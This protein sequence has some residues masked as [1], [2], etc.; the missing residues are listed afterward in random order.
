MD[1][2][3]L[4]LVDV[5]GALLDVAR[6]AEAVFGRL[7]AS[8]LNWKPDVAQWSIA[9]CFDHLLNA[10]RMMFSA[11]A[12]ALSGKQPRT[13][14]ERVP[15][16]PRVLGPML[17][18]SQA[19]AS[20]RKF[21]AP[22]QA[23]PAESDLPADIIARFVVHHRELADAVAALDERRA[24]ALVMTSPFIGV[25]TYSVLDGWRL[26]VAHDHRHFEQARRVRSLWLAAHSESVH[27]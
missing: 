19:P 12:E 23:R 24:A 2:T 18:R 27:S 9:Q 16:L 6:D 3:N 8:Q 14:W 17:I 25:V 21:V 22:A 26:I 4:T 5:R 7:N 15:I 10:N 1:Y 20:T 13:L 11:A